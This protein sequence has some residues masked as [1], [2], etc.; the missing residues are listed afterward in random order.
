L[1][2]CLHESIGANKPDNSG[3]RYQV[4]ILHHLE[5]RLALS[6]AAAVWWRMNSRRNAVQAVGRDSILRMY[7]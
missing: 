5:A 4:G 2:V 7:S 6:K 3:I 1:G